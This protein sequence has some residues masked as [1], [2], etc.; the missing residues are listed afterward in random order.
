MS[1]SAASAALQE[2]ESRYDIQLFDRAGKRLRLNSFGESI[3]IK[4]EA[5]MAHL[6]EFEDEL[7]GQEELGHLRV[8]ASLTIGNYLAVKHLA[9]Y[10]Q[11]HPG[12][13]VEMEVGSTPE[14]VAKVLNFHLDIGLIEAELH[15]D[16]LLLQPW[17]EDKMVVFC[18]ADH[19]LAAK[20]SLTNKDL[21][22]AD[23]ILRESDSGHRQ[24]FDRSM[25]GL[26]PEL[27]IVLELTHNEAIKNAVKAGLGVG[28]LSE[29]AIADEIQQGVLV[30]LTVK[31]RPM[32]RRF[33]FVTHR[34]ASVSRAAQ[35]WI[36]IC[37]R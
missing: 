1:Q 17:R 30:P 34:Q 14:V 33:Y 24:T 32:H 27:N 16:D 28:C 3:R 15:H 31:G 9:T 36:E 12:A 2:F 11:E 6:R 18:R 13:K 23:W 19:P 8:G 26:L 10:L 22:A 5:V 37:K 29:I 4:A 20:P 25:Q 21:L 35:S 7:Q